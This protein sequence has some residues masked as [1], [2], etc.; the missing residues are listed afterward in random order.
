LTLP[1]ALWRLQVSCDPCVL[2]TGAP[3]HATIGSSTRDLPYRGS[4]RSMPLVF[5]M[6]LAISSIEDS[7][8]SSIGIE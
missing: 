6:R 2:R 8:V 7:L 1:G 5:M 3:N 4:R